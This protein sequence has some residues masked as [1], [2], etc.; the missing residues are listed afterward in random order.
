[1]KKGIKM[2]V[3]SYG[4]INSILS[5]EARQDIFPGIISFQILFIKS[6]ISSVLFYPHGAGHK[7]A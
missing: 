5:R 1:M 7:N 3:D 6:E 2:S 4:S